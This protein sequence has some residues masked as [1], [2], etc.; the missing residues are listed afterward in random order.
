MTCGRNLI[1]EGALGT[2]HLTLDAVTCCPYLTRV[3]M[4]RRVLCRGQLA[5]PAG[6]CFAAARRTRERPPLHLSS[7]RTLVGGAV[8]QGDARPASLYYE[9]FD[10]E[11]VGCGGW[12]PRRTGP[13]GRGDEVGCGG[14]FSGEHCPCIGSAKVNEIFHGTWPTAGAVPVGSVAKFMGPPS[15]SRVRIS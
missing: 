2:R 13:A 7:T 1:I 12:D 11:A 15:F 9:M 8:P 3:S 5:P 6:I 10:R 4:Y 14:G